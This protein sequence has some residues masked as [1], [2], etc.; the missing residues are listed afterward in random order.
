[1]LPSL[2]TGTSLA[3]T[4]RQ[5]P[6]RSRRQALIW[7]VL[8]LLTGVIVTLGLTTKPT[9]QLSL[10]PGD[11]TR[12]RAED[13]PL[14]TAINFTLRDA[15]RQGNQNAPV[16][17]I[18][19]SDFQCAYCWQF[20]RLVEPELFKQYIA[21]GQVT[22]VFKHLPALGQESIW[23]AEAAECAADQDKFWEYHDALFDHLTGENDGTFI[24]DNLLKYARQIDLDLGQFEPCLTNDQTLD[25][26]QLDQ[27]ESE[28]AGV[29]GTPTFFINGQPLIGAQPLEIFQA[30]IESKLNGK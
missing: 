7:F 10:S 13:H 6:A 2:A 3:V 12:D 14:P 29:L 18:E 30:A 8:G 22:F 1:M 26:V 16:T 5:S 28:Q 17:I 21:T 27:R 11:I 25:R 4:A 19:F 20:Y 24:K 9:P 15:N 23:A